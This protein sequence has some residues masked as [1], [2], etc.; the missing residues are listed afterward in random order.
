MAWVTRAWVALSPGGVVRRMT[1][2]TGGAS[3]CT[4]PGSSATSW[5]PVGTVTRPLTTSRGRDSPGSSGRGTS[6]MRAS[7]SLDPV[8]EQGV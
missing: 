8:A 7:Q 6:T 2:C 4:G 3:R 1:C 5:P